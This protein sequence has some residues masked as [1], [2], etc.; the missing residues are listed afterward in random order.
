[1]SLKVEVGTITAP[2]GTGNQTYNL[3]DSGFGAVKALLLWASYNTAEGDVGANGIF[4]Q[5]FGTFRGG[6]SQQYCIT[7]F[8]TDGVGTSDV[9]RGRHAD[10][11]LRGLSAATPT[12]DYVAALVSLGTAAFTLNWS[13]APGSQIKV[14]YLALGGADITDALIVVPDITQAAGTQDITV[15]SGFGQPDLLIC[16]P[17]NGVADTDANG[18]NY[19][20]LGVGY[21]DANERHSHWNARDAQAVMDVASHQTA[22]LMCV[23]NN[24]SGGSIS[25]EVELSA[26]SAWPTDGFQVNKLSAPVGAD[27]P[28][29]TLA[30]RGS[31]SKAVG[32]MTVPTDAA[33]QIQDLAVGGTPRGA[34]FF[35]NS[36]LPNAGTDSSSGDLGTFGLGAT[37]GVHEAWEGV[38]QDDG[39]TTSVSHRNHSES[40][41]IKMFTPSAAG[42]LASEADGSFS[43][44]NVRLTWGDTDTVAREYCYLLLGD[45]PVVE[46]VPV[47]WLKG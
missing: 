43:G 20:G 34:L 21:D 24:A 32:A 37:D 35:H 17:S 38:G 4:S 16:L 42:T 27:Q 26:R 36:V 28:L 23:L 31:F 47:A 46:G 22:T 33:P 6:S 18:N 8:D 19:L 9:A 3:A 44:N 11:I 41:S 30:L 15:A 25:Y 13:D 5:G 39:N 14:N 1:M 40:K 12:V 10:G 29:A 7:Y 2:A 45:A